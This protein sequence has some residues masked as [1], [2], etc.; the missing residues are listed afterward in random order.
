MSKIK[1]S[2]YPLVYPLPAALVGAI[3]DNKVNYETLGDCGIVSVYP[4]VLYISSNKS[5]H[6]NKGILKNKCFSVNIPSVDL[7]D[8][9]DYCGIVT[10]KKVDKSNVFKI[11]YGNNKDIP[12]IEECPINIACKVKETI[13]IYNMKVFFGDIIETYVNEN[14]F[15]DGHI[16][17]LKINPLIYC[18]DNLY[19]TIGKSVGKG[20]NSGKNYNDIIK[21]MDR[22]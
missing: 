8:K 20:F 18:M 1:Y 10:G 11:Y 16:D 22:R 3:V 17:T 4:P 9:V 2:K 19:W 21:N 12:L 5:H 6:T 14:C 7:L 15:T 13:D